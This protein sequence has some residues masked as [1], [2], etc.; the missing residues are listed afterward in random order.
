MPFRVSAKCLA[1]LEWPDLTARLAAGLRTAQGLALFEQAPFADSVEAAR[2]RLSETTEARALQGGGADLPFGAL[3]SLATELLRLTKGGALSA[4]ELLVIGALAR[5]VA[6]TRGFF[7]R[8]SGE[9][10]LLA[11]RASALSDPRPLAD[12]IE[13]ALDSSGGV[14]DSASA[15]LAAARRE[16]QEAAARVRERVD[17]LL[18]ERELRGA[19]QDT[20]VTMRG[21]RYVLPVRAEARSRVPGIVHDASASGTTLFIEP[22]AVVGLNNRL[23]EAELAI[24]RETRRVLMDLSAQAAPAAPALGADLEVLAHLD[25]AFAR[26]RLAGELDA[27]EPILDNAGYFE[28]RQLRHPLLPA[29]AVPNDLRLGGGFH[30]LVISGPNAGGKTVAMK[31]LGLAALMA[32][33]GLHV[34]AAAGSRVGAVD[35]VLA[36]IGDEQ[37]IRESLSTFSA[38]LA[39]LA[40]ILAEAGPRSLVL[41]DEIGVGTD[42]GEGAALAQAVLEALADAEARVIATTHF[43]LLKEMADVDARFENACVDFD[44][45]TLAPTYRLRLGIAGASSARAVAARMGM[46]ASVLERA[47]GLLAREDRR[48]D[49]MLAELAASRAALER[50]RSEAAR[51]QVESETA[52]NDYRAK[53]ER[54]QERRDQLFASMREGLDGAFQSAHAE[55]AAVIRELQRG[56][57]AQ[58]AARARDRLIELEKKTERAE[59]AERTPTPGLPQ[60]RADWGQTRP[61]DPVEVVGAGSGTLLALP[62]ARGRVRVQVGGARLTV[63]GERVRGR[64]A[65]PTRPAPPTVRVDPLPEHSTPTRVDVRGL[66]LEEAMSAVEQA[67]DDAARAGLSYLEILHGLGTGALMSGVRERLRE[68]AHVKRVEPGGAETGGPGVTLAFLG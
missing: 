32:R 30:V 34:A 39:N 67:L 49:Q 13:R 40:A 56:G 41:L 5:A 59:P 61:G 20:F 65:A 15:A 1:R 68:L 24:E 52:R 17:R 45:E 43:G 11:A 21:D 53:L 66:R 50:E 27:T 60:P 62:D 4:A 42:P 47:N 9:A 63:L 46:P 3:P 28:L 36:D 23:K 37:D 57:S 8:R 2:H 16:A 6:N 38:H 18:S 58:D 22:E 19:L 35:A 55:V 10:P 26:G 12:A 33:A 44:E 25:L 51:L 14:R 64:S 54:L 29:D 7:S 31:A 48:L